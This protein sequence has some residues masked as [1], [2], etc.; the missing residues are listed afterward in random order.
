MNR[1]HIEE[2]A[3][4]LQCPLLIVHGTADPVVLYEEAEMLHQW[5]PD[6]QLLPIPDANHVFGMRHPWTGNELPPHAQTMTNAT[7]D[8]F[9]NLP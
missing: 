2:A 8:F 4:S 3:K 1:L 6:S 7:I 5:Q 9:K